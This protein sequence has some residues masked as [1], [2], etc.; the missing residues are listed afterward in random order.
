[1]SLRKSQLGFSAVE[2][3]I[4]V[5]I[6]AALALVGY[7]VYNR[8][9]NK[10]A[11][12]TQPTNSQATATDVPSAPAISSTSDLDKASAVLDQVDPGASNSNDSSQLDSQLAT[13]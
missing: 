6:V 7:T 3:T 11:T 5:V 8:Q 10:T 4:I 1:M 9:N 12:T 2:L 13:F